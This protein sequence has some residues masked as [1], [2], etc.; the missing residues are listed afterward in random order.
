MENLVAVPIK[1]RIRELAEVKDVRTLVTEGSLVVYVDLKDEVGNVN[2]T[3]QRLRDKMDNVKVDCPTAPSAHLSTATSA[4][5]RLPPLQLQP[6]GF[7][8][9]T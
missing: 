6:R 3:W 7:R 2:A 5:L 9:A 1:R 4:T 8:F